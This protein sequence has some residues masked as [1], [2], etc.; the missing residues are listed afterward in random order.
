M[1]YQRRKAI[2]GKY[3]DE[4]DSQLEDYPYGQGV[5]DR[6]ALILDNW[7]ALL[8]PGNRYRD[9]AELGDGDEVC[10]ASGG[11]MVYAFRPGAGYFCGD[12]ESGAPATNFQND[13][14]AWSAYFSGRYEINDSGLEAFADVLYYDAK[15]KNNN[16]WIFISE[17]ILDLTKP[18]PLPEF[19]FDFYQWDTVQRLWN[20]KELGMDLSEKY[21]DTAWTASGGLRGVFA[22]IHD[23][24]LSVNYSEYEFESQRP[25]LKWRET[26]DNLLGTHFGP[27]FFGTDWWSGGTLGE[28]LGFGIGDPNNVF[29]PANQALRDSI[30]T[31][32]YGNESKRTATRSRA[33]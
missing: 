29:G 12:P 22:D 24:E 23:W 11:G 27:S 26:I 16:Q 20:G 14:E 21:K 28:G 33:C 17:D 1:E 9:P 19:G 7:K 13:K 8:D 18:V 31:Q 10:S 15:S 4:F 2:L 30:G 6:S 3:Y 5:Y 25:W 32:T